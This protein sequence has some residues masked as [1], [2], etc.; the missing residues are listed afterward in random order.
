MEFQGRNLRKGRHSQPG[1]IYLLTTVTHQRE[2]V[3]ADW[4]VGRLLVRQLRQVETGGLASSLAWVVMPDHFHWLVQLHEASLSRLV[5]RVKSCSAVRVNE[6][7]HRSGP[8]WQKGFH[9]HALRKEE[10]LREL[11]RY[12]IANPLRARLVARVGDYP[13]WDAI[14]L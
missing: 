14:W 4:R 9:D 11:A 13:L 2:P 5:Q 8:V 6:Q 10:D 12:I 3:F 7:L 1:G